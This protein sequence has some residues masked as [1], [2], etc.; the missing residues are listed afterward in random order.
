VF[1]VRVIK[2]INRRTSTAVEETVTGTFAAYG[3]AVLVASGM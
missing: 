3:L 1:D 2:K